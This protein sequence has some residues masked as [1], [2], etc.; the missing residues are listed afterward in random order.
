MTKIVK[1][2]AACLLMIALLSGVMLLLPPKIGWSQG[3]SMTFT[4]GETITFHCTTEMTFWS[5]VSM[6][7]GTGLI[8]QFVEVADGDGIIEPCDILHWFGPGYMP[9]LCDWFEILDPQ[10]N[11]TGFEFHIDGQAGPTEWHIDAVYPGPF[12]LPFPGIPFLAEKKVD[13]IEPCMYFVAHLPRGWYPQPCSWWEIMD[14][15]TGHATGFEFHV[16]WT[17]E[18][19]E[20]HVDEVIPGPYIPPFPW[21]EIEARKKIDIIN[22]CDWF[23]IIDPAGFT[24]TPCSWWEILD[25]QTGAPTGLEFH[26]DQAGSGTFH[27]DVTNPIPLKIPP[28][29]PTRVRQKVDTIEPCRWF[30]VDDPTVT[31]KAGTW[32]RIERPSIGDVEFHVDQYDPVLGRFHV[33]QVLPGSMQIPPTYDLT[34]EKKFTGISPCDWL[35]VKLP[36]GFLPSPCT[37]WRIT[38]PQQWAGVEFHVDSNDGISRF[39]IDE[40][41]PL[42]PGPTPPPFEVTAENFEP[43]SPWYWKPEF[44]DYAPSGMPDFDQRQWGTYNWTNQGAWSHCGPLAVANSLWWLDSEFELNPIPPPVINDSFRLVQSYGQWDDHSPQNVQPLVEHL[45]YLMDTDGRRTGLVHSG[46]NVHDMEAGINHYLSWTGVNPRGDVNGD[47]IVDV[48]DQNL[49]MAAMGSV[50]GSPNWNLAADIFPAST[51]YPPVAD[52]IINMND[53][54]LVAANMG[55]TGMFYEHTVQTPDFNFIETEVKKCQDVV[56]L[57]GYWVFNQGTWYREPGGH[58][59]TVAGVDSTNVKIAI[60]DPVQD[61]FENGLIPEG[62]IPVPHVHMPPQPPYVT[63]NDARYVS[64]DIYQVMNVTPPWPP[65]PGGNLMLANFAS[66]RPAPPFFAVVEYAVVTSPRGVHD[67]AVTNVT[68][69]KTLLGKA[70]PHTPG[71]FCCKVNVTVANQGD[72]NETFNV[73]LNANTTKV[74]SITV[75]NLLNGTTREITFILNCSG[76]VMGKYNITAIADTVFGETDT[77][78]NTLSDGLVRIGVPCDIT[79]P[80]PGVPDDVCNMRDIGY[81]CSKFGTTTSSPNWDPNADVTGPTIGMPDDVVNMRD[82]GEAAKHFGEHA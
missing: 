61:A 32:W 10:G 5:G 77:S 55:K 70:C 80:T 15:E 41:D 59:V 22:P 17:N 11:P 1:G 78:D 46:T 54:A 71:G 73:T 68:A 14:P 29:Y 62:R 30:A 42:P 25:P 52:N 51:V 40:I 3:T 28:S 53:A 36:Q 66:W 27:V 35:K 72:Y 39:H 48:N 58:Y 56:L 79:G 64:Q 38:S 37:W 67:V 16:D 44:A 50:P 18:S 7:L 23:T 74:G 2:N 76:L 81:F 26:V 69:F 4:T 31:P 24:P 34:A 13:R 19:C 6:K 75:N 33:D 12:P 45:A 21:Y 49:V 65:C 47:G 43:S 9:M 60:S 63:H 20:F 82:I 57:I 8:V